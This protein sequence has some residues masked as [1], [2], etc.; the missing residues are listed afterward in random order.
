M[1]NDSRVLT[2]FKVSSSTI[3]VIEGSK[4][5]IPGTG[6]L[7]LPLKANYGTL[8]L[9][10]NLDAVFV[11]SCPYNSIPPYLLISQMKCSGY[12]EKNISIR[13]NFMSLN[14]QE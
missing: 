1:V 4:V 7:Q 5:L 13:T 9:V 6:K 8:D 10:P 12:A 3:K 14:M 11:P 2:K